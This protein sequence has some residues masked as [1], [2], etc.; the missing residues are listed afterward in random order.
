MRRQHDYDD[1]ASAYDRFWGYFAD[2]VYPVLDRLVLPRVEPGGHV[3]D[4][5][6]GTGRLAGLV[7][8]A[9]YRVTGVDGSPAM[10]QHARA[11][12]PDAEFVLADAREFTLDAPC[13][14]AVSTFDSLNHLM[15]VEDLAAAFGSVRACLV[16]GAPFL[17]DLNTAEGFAARWTG[18]FGRVDD[19]HVVAGSSSWAPETG[20]ARGRL[21]VMTRTGATWQRADVSIAERCHS[22]ADVRAALATSGFGNVTVFDAAADL[23]FDEVGRVFYLAEA[24]SG[25]DRT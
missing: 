18:S 23:G 14:A 21:T 6:C 5:C 12:A 8:S 24:L 20:E 10:L 13:D 2:L 16:G 7:S 15:T 11:N 19:D 17:F 9:G 1:F 4:V 3:L 22:D 25:G